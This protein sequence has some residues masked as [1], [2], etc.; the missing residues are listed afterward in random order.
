M[1]GVAGWSGV[2]LRLCCSIFCPV[3]NEERRDD[4]QENTDAYTAVCQIKRGEMYAASVKIQKINHR[5]KTQAVHHV[6]E[7]ATDNHGNGGA[8]ERAGAFA[9]PEQKKQDDDE[10][11]SAQN[12]GAVIG[13]GM[14]QAKTDSLIPH[15]REV[16][17]RQEEDLRKGQAL[18]GL[19]HPVREG[20]RRARF[21]QC[22]TQEH[23]RHDPFAEL[24]R[25]EHKGREAE[26]QDLFHEAGV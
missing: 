6:P 12:Q 22:A 13:V 8:L 23:F 3:F 1:R 9:E 10:R 11:E 24:V 17:K 19:K 21:G 25:P 20:H 5:A 7:R 26:E 15:H 4:Q 16:E 2:C 18:G 14:Q